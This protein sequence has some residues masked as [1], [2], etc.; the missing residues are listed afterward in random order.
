MKL[1][2]YTIEHELD[3]IV[4]GARIHSNA[5]KPNLD[6]PA[7]FNMG[8]YRYFE[9]IV[10]VAHAT[11]LEESKGK[12]ARQLNRNPHLILTFVCM[13]TPPSYCLEAEN[14]DIIWIDPDQQESKTFNTIQEVFQRFN[15]WER[16][17]TMIIERGGG[18]PD[19]VN[20]S[21]KIFKNDL[22]ITDPFSRVL[23]YRVYRNERFPREQTDLIKEGEYLP[24]SMIFDGVE[25]EQDRK[26]SPSCIP[27][28]SMMA[29]FR[30]TV[31][32][33]TISLSQG[34]ALVLSVHPNHHPVGK[35]DF[36]PMLTFSAAVE[37]L[38][39][40]YRTS[41]YGKP[42]TN[43]HSS[44]KAL[45]Q[46]EYVS[47]V[48][49]VQS[50]IAQGWSQD[51]DEYLCLCIDFSSSTQI[52]D[53]SFMR[54]YLAVCNRLQTTFDCVSFV[55]DSRIA[56]IVNRS[57]MAVE[58]ELFF[59]N[60]RRLAEDY[61]LIAGSSAPYFGLRSLRDSYR[62]AF[63]ALNMAYTN[64]DNRLIL[65]SEH[66]LDIGMNFIMEQMNPERFCPHTL[67]E[68]AQQNQDL[69]LILKTYL[70][71]NCNSNEAS[72]RLKLQRNS[73]VYRLEKVKKLLG[74][75]LNDPDIR[76]LL[77]I[78]F[79]LIDLYGLSN[80]EFLASTDHRTIY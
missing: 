17:L 64:G 23:A 37:K 47:D 60:F 5:S 30:C 36:A 28:F 38:Y 41:E 48:D 58:D 3:G 11:H 74:L 1:S 33:S 15:S 19:L 32:R 59:A 77:L 42:Y 56:A 35:N 27:T 70:M 21:F 61:H 29:A 62:Q 73:F 18:L 31:L 14:C 24:K 65:F 45:I 49:L 22:C 10:Y 40:T 8:D 68:L 80:M 39:A 9:H 50:A 57:R 16:E 72:K 43:T 66:A 71:S 54:P 34:Y 78:S 75:D 46:G 4:A 55:A 20:A 51:A 79:K 6:Y 44:L 25:D 7:L 2:L 63:A 76:L 69:F 13:G 12:I 67:L 52:Q 53:Y 26:F